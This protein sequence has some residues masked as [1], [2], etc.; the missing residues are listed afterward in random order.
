MPPR[1]L[2]LAVFDMDG[3]LVDV[4]SSWVLVHEHFGTDNDDS[5]GAFLRGEIDDLE[6]IARDV[7]RWR[8]ARGDVT[9]EEVRGVLDS[10]PLV[11]GAIETLRLLRAEGVRTAIVSGGLLHLAQRVAD[12]GGVDIVFANDIEVDP[13]G[14]LT[15]VGRA[16]VP[17]LE[18]ASVMQR[19]Q[20]ELGVDIPATA[21]LGN[22]SIDIPMFE[23]AGVSIAF[24]PVD[25][26][27]AAAATHVIRGRDL[28]AVLPVLLD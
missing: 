5:L 20:R 28:R 10:A 7:A 21:A 15:G 6:F 1:Q 23:R 16:P 8:R 12:A 22:S 17:L 11:P 13:R 27:T 25:E 9:W 19:I 2:R 26:R 18:K 24:N 14:I 4:E 3:V